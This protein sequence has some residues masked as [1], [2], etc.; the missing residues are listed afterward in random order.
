MKHWTEFLPEAG[1]IRHISS[2]ARLLMEEIN[3]HMRKIQECTKLL[4]EEDKRL[5]K[6][7]SGLWTKKEIRDAMNL[8][9]LEQSRIQEQDLLN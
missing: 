4:Q 5:E 8:K 7:A 3:E 9:N 1:R 2:S 6:I